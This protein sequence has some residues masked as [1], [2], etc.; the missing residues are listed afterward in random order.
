[1]SLFKI[2]KVVFCALAFWF[3]CHLTYITI[4]G[5]RANNQKADLAVILGSKVNEEGTLSERLEKRMDCGLALYQKGQ[6]KKILVSGGLGKEGHYEGSKMKDFLIRNGVPDTAI[7]V[8]DRGDNTRATVNNT[9]SLQDS[10]H[11]NSLIVVSQYFHVTRT[12]MLFRKRGFT[13]VSGASPWYF[14]IRDPYSLTREFFA[15]YLQ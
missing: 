11:F 1:M 3:I 15:Y 9:L 6:V 13:N 7:V 5:L 4:D 10:L 8:D 14:E 12:K 2:L